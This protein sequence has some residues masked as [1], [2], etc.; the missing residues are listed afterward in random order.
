MDLGLTIEPQSPSAI[1]AT[2]ACP[3]GCH[4]EV[5]YERGARPASDTCCCG[6]Q[7]AVGLGADHHLTQRVGV[8][9]HL[10]RF[11]T[12]WGDALPAVWAIGPSTHDDEHAHEHVE[13]DAPSAGSPSSSEPTDA[14]IDPVCGMT[15]EL[16]AARTKGLHALYQAREYFFCGR[17][18]KLEFDEDPEYYL[19]PGYVPSM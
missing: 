17:G 4:P 8:E 10:E 13:R 1:Q 18:C 19:D 7:F 2:Y 12:P 14:A 16:H 9:M 3:C 5:R 6:N 11:E 15:V